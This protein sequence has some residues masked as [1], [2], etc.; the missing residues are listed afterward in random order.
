MDEVKV[1]LIDPP[2]GAEVI[3]GTTLFVKAEI[4]F[5]LTSQGSGEVALLVQ[6]A[7]QRHDTFASVTVGLEDGGVTVEG[8]FVVP[9]RS[10]TEILVHLRRADGAVLA[11][12][13]AATYKIV[14]QPL[15]PVV[16]GADHLE[17]SSIEPP[18]G[19]PLEPGTVVRIIAKVAYIF[20]SQPSGFVQLGYREP[21]GGFSQIAEQQVGRGSDEREIVFD[22]SLTVPDQ[23]TIR[24]FVSLA[25]ADGGPI[26]TIEVAAYP[27]A[28]LPPGPASNGRQGGVLRIAL[29]GDPAPNG[30]FDY[31]TRPSSRLLQAISPAFNGLVEQDTQDPSSIVPGLAASWEISSDGAGWTFTLRQGVTFHNGSSLD[32]GD[33]ALTLEYILTNASSVVREDL[34]RMVAKWDVRDD[35]TLFVIL[36]QPFAAFLPVLGQGFMNVYPSEVM[37]EA[38]DS[39]FPTDPRVAL[40]GT[41]PFRFSVYAP[42]EKLAY[43]RWPAYFVTD[44]PYLDQLDMFIIPN[45][46]RRMAALLTGQID[47]SLERLTPKESAGLANQGFTVSTGPLLLVRTVDFNTQAGPWREP[48]VRRAAS[49]A[50]DRAAIREVLLGGQGSGGYYMPPWG[51]WAS[52]SVLYD[53]ERAKA[54][55][56]EAGFPDG[57]KTTMTVSQFADR[58]NVAEIVA[59]MWSQFGI[60]TEVEITEFATWAARIRAGEYSTSIGGSAFAVD[61]PDVILRRLYAS[62]GAANFTG[63][64]SPLF[65]RLLEMQ[66][67]MADPQERRGIVAEMQSILADLS[68]SAVVY[69]DDMRQ[70]VSPD[71][72]DYFLP[73]SLRSRINFANVWLDR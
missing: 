5:G 44:R 64:S 46:D 20:Q 45:G 25:G 72:K 1:G 19:T 26:R 8:S 55:L 59:E 30:G 47:L 16:A 35:R 65:D 18:S 38:L 23:P 70:G 13:R 31:Y 11:Q 49:V 2:D 48:P 67:T 54:L 50:I 39:G 29:G 69:W 33:V 52:E 21:G 36:N 24:L 4:G 60:E 53:P 71:I 32:A 62:D 73:Q 56:A 27:R 12:V 43:E 9:D 58:L 61:D 41:G 42:G 51:P 57:F 15:G 68:P 40:T 37:R 17:V 6:V 7:D 14:Q 22:A 34:A 10:A 28:E 3:V 63:F 66:S